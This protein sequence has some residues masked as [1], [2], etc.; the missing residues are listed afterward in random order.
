MYMYINYIINDNVQQNVNNMKNIVI[1]SRKIKYHNSL[2]KHIR[3]ER[4]MT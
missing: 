2:L 4:K 3:R 1:F